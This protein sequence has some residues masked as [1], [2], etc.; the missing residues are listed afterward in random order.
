MQEAQKQLVELYAVV[1]CHNNLLLAQL[2]LK[3]QLRSQ[4]KLERCALV[5]I[6]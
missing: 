2:E 6:S 1:C 4:L 3:A 5:Q